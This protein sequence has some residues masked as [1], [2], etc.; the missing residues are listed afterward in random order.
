MCMSSSSDDD[1]SNHYLHDIAL[2]GVESVFVLSL[3]SLPF[4]VSRLRYQ[5]PH[6]IAYQVSASSDFQHCKE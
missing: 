4:E 5:I 6:H 2:F 3:V 1:A